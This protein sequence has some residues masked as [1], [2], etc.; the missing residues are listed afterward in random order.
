MKWETVEKAV[1]YET[2]AAWAEGNYIE[3]YA[4]KVDVGWSK[5]NHR[6][7]QVPLGFTPTHILRVVD[8]Q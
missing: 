3:Y 4:Y 5:T 2:V 8:P 6:H 1:L 7:D